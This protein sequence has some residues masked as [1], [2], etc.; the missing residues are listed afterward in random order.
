MRKKIMKYVLVAIV[1]VA[2]SFVVYRYRIHKENEIPPINYSE[3]I[4]ALEN[5]EVKSITI[6][7]SSIEAEVVLNNG[8]YTSTNILNVDELKDLVKKHVMEGNKVNLQILEEKDMLPTAFEICFYISIAGCIALVI[9][10]IIEHFFTKPTSQS[11]VAVCNEGGDNNSSSN[12][13]NSND[14]IVFD[15]IAG[16]DEEKTE[17]LEI[18]DFLKS[19]EKYQK[20]GARIPKG[21]LLVGPPGTGK[22]L[23]AKAVAGEADVPFINTTGSSFVEKYVGVGAKRIRELFEKARRNAPCIIFIDEIDALGGKRS[24]SDEGGDGERHQTLEQ[25]LSEMDGFSSD[26]CD[27]IV[28]GATNRQSALDP[29]FTRPGRFDRIV[30][31]NLPDLKAREAILRLHGKNK[32]F[33]DDVSF[34]KVAYNTSGF[35][36]AGLEN[37]LNEAAILAARKNHSAISDEDISEAMRKVVIGLQKANKVISDHDKN[38]TAYH[39]AG[40]AICGKVLKTCSTIK[41]ICIIP[42]GSA[43]GYTWHSGEPDKSYHSKQEMEERI[44]SLLAGQAAEKIVFGE[45][46]TGASDDLEKAT[47]I[48]TQMVAYY[49]MCDAIGPISIAGNNNILLDILG[50]ELSSEMGK[51]IREIIKSAQSTAE[52]KLRAYIDL[53][54][55]LAKLLIKKETVYGCEL[56]ELFRKYELD[57]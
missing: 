1:I 52:E 6:T 43:G 37:L 27:I 12:T 22:T 54:H 55:E 25:F 26:S 17:L 30:Q 56:D 11:D 29:A 19:P 39:E 21:I 49:G 42:R 45:I 3:L 9:S 46:T 20:L 50:N 4:T 33:M 48:A 44:I 14:L 24:D 2:I 34:E 10:S 53:L 57:S 28:I 47:G 35:S 18:V 36:G 31:V 8:S 16:L 13:E 41:E 38:I 51:E 7:E 40:H 15:S 23:L 32:P 5:D